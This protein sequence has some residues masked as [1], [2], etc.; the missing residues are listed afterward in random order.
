MRKRILFAL[1]SLLVSFHAAAQ[2]DSENNIFS[3]PDKEACA[4][5]VPVVTSTY[6][7]GSIA[8]TFF[9]D[10]DDPTFSRQLVS[11]QPIPDFA[12][13]PGTYRM[14]VVS[15]ADPATQV[16]D[17]FTIT[18][19]PNEVPVFDIYTCSANRVQINIEDI[20]FPEYA[21]DYNNDGSPDNTSAPG[22][23]S[24]PFTYA[25]TA[26]QTITVRPNYT[27]CTA[28][29]KTVTPVAGAIAPPSIINELVVSG[30]PN[31]DLALITESNY[32]Y[33]LDISSNSASGWS[34]L[35]D[36]TD[37]S[38]LL[39]A[40]LDTEANYYCFRLGTVNI[41]DSPA[42]LYSGSNIICSADLDLAVQNDVMSLTWATSATGASGFTLS[43][44]PGGPQLLPTSPLRYDD[45]D[46]ICGTAYS[47]QLVN[48][49]GSGIRSYSKV[50]SGVA[51]SDRAPS[52]IADISSVIEP[53]GVTLTWVQDPGFIAQVYEV[54]TDKNNRS[55]S[56]GTT[57]SPVFT[58]NTFTLEE[59]ICYR[60]RYKDICNNQSDISRSVCPIEL[61]AVLQKNNSVVLS[62][63]PYGGWSNGVGEYVIEKYDETG[64]LV[65]LLNAGNATSFSDPEVPG[66]TEQI[67][68]YRV[69]ALPADSPA[70]IDPS[71]SNIVSIVKNPNFAHPTAFIPGSN[72]SENKSFKVYGNYIQNYQL[73]I[74]NRWG[75]LIF[76]SREQEI[77]WD[78]TFRG[79]RM[80]EGTYVFQALVTD[81]A[82]RQFEYAGTVVLLKKG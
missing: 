81:F 24:P 22:L 67:F 78:G 49:Y 10:A 12:Y 52:T 45:T 8:C 77:G 82:G 68:S 37:E 35:Q 64:T 42:P 21:I 54:F 59:G 69:R 2:Y 58:D 6:C 61:T 74:F 62:W 32:L 38:T 53:S 75:E 43:K 19:Y 44:N 20:G 66:S 72:I 47:Y 60:I 14:K 39:I 23:V 5:Y 70:A 7:S 46:I 30:Q 26:L 27:G 1:L 56:I 31:I 33:Q 9:P 51:T 65:A 79:Q 13:E 36:V 17:F 29:S 18:I 55:F 73:K 48:E 50:V 16:V 34:K 63:N 40:G 80:P 15:G 76:E 25:S 57:T 28:T 71:L 11:G 4:P 3:V 41:C